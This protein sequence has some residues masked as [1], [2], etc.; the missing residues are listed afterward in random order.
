MSCPPPH[1]QVHVSE[2]VLGEAKQISDYAMVVASDDDGVTNGMD[3]GRLG[4]AI[5]FH[6]LRGHKEVGKW[7]GH[8]APVTS[9]VVTLLHH[10]AVVISIP[11]TH[12][13]VTFA[14]RTHRVVTHTLHTH[15]CYIHNLTHIESE[16]LWRVRQV[17]GH[18][19][20]WP[21]LISKHS[22]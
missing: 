13:V 4:E 5:V 1:S 19:L 3:T 14:H 8:K 22:T 11:G 6:F 17:G 21:N 18:N 9:T 12:K 16:L 10:S 7:H 15:I 20:H 2:K